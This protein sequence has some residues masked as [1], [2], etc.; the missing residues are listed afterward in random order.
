MDIELDEWLAAGTRIRMSHATDALR[1]RGNGNFK[2]QYRITHDTLTARSRSYAKLVQEIVAKSKGASKGPEHWSYWT[3]YWQGPRPR[4]FS[5]EIEG[6]IYES[7]PPK[8]QTALLGEN[9]TV[10]NAAA[11]SVAHRSTGMA[12]RPSSGRVGFDCPSGSVASRRTR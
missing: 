11:G 4:L 12:T 2:F 9:P 10:K 5:A 6:P 8:R 7:W 3:E 1:L